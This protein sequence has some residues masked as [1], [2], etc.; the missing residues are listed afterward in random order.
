M[1]HRY[2]TALETPSVEAAQQEYGSH[3]AMR[4]LIAGWD[5]DAELGEDEVA[6]LAERDSFYLGT[7]GE[8]GWPYVQH[9]GGP[10]GF[11]KV[12]S[13]GLLGWA[14]YRGNR[15]YVSVGNLRSSAK[16][17]LFLMDYA[18]QRRLKILG[19]ARVVD[20][21]RPDAAALV[22]DVGMPGYR[23][24]VERVITVEVH[25]YDWNCPQ[26]ITPRWTQAELTPVLAKLH[27]ELADLRDTNRRL[28][29]ELAELRGG[30]AV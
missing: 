29:R 2:L 5:T 4:R 13:A 8:S 15:Q 28:R 18:Q 14:D 12:L 7:T 16:V 10:P 30:A 1:P 25:G 26:H 19:E 27:G 9:R 21:R 6:F 22:A 11:L 24:H 17:S 23:A 3:T 20:A